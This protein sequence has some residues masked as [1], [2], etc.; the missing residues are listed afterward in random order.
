MLAAPRARSIPPT[1]EK[2]I[3]LRCPVL[4]DVTASTRDAKLAPRDGDVQRQR[5]RDELRQDIE[6]PA[7]RSDVAT[8]KRAG[9]RAVDAEAL[10]IGQRLSCKRR[11]DG[12]CGLLVEA[13]DDGDAR[14]RVEQSDQA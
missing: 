14:D 2:C 13:G 10:R 3:N 11:V 8:Q 9:K 1:I 5:V 7:D 6:V 12:N 4:G